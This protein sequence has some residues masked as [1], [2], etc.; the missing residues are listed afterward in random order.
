[1][2]ERGLILNKGEPLTFS[3]VLPSDLHKHVDPDSFPHEG[4]PRTLDEIIS[5]YIR[6]ILVLTK[7]KIHGPGGAAELLGVNPT[8][9][10]SRMKKLHIPFKRS[11]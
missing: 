8:T 5:D 9:L 2:V 1:V 7:G 6:H 4:P 3:L 10:R 11:R